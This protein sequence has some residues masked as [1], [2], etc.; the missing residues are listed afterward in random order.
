MSRYRRVTEQDRIAIWKGLRAGLSQKDIACNLGFHKSTISRE[1]KRNG[2]LKGYR[3]KQAHAMAM[4][5]QLHRFVPRKMN[6]HRKQLIIRLLKRR[7][8]PE[9]ICRR[10]DFEGNATISH[11]TIY[12]MILK[13]RGNG[14]SLWRLLRRSHRK[15]RPRNP[16]LWR[17]RGHLQASSELSVP[18]NYQRSW[19]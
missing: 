8:S 2:G 13:D 3:F 12:R 18:Y 15:R 9:M 19:S 1:L 16:D 11:E 7:W 5:R 10:L 17:K 4:D 6:L 14:G